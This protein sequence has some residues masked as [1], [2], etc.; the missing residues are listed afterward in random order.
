VRKKFQGK[1]FA[2]MID[3]EQASV[4]ALSLDYDSEE[5]LGDNLELFDQELMLD[6][7]L[8]DFKETLVSWR[9]FIA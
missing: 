3:L 8:T 1:T 4:R 6:C 9:E 2:L 5:E 7:G